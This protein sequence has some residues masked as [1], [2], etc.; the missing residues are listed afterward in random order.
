MDVASLIVRVS[1]TGVQTTQAQL[2]RLS[3]TA[4]NAQKSAGGLNL[5]MIGLTATLG[6]LTKEAIK[7]GDEWTNINSKLNLVT[8]TTQDFNKAQ[9]ELFNISQNTRTSL[10]AS[11]EL[12]RKLAVS[13]ESLNIS[14]NRLL[15][16]TETIN[17]AGIV[18]GGSKESINA[19]LIQ[20]G[21][22]LASGALRGEELNSV[23]EQ[24]P[25]LAKLIADG[26]GV[27]VGALKSLAEAG[28]ITSETIIKA[29][30]AGEKGIAKEFDVVQATISSAMDVIEGS[31][32][33][34]VG[35]LDSATGATRSLS[36]AMIELSKDI[37]QNN[38]DI[39][40]TGQFIYATISRTIDV[41]NVLYESVENTGQIVVGNINLLAYGSLEV[42]LTMLTKVTE[43]LNVLGLASDKGL[44]E[45]YSDLAY[46][47]G[48]VTNANN[49]IADSYDDLNKA[50]IKLSP[51]IEDRIKGY[52]AENKA[53]TEKLELQKKELA[54][55]Q[56]KGKSKLEVEAELK[57]EKEKQE[58]EKKSKQQA[59]KLAEDWSKRNIE[60]TTNMAIA[61]QDELAK[62]FIVL[63]A[64]YKEDLETFK[65]VK[66]A[67]ERLTLEY[68][69]EVERQLKDLTEK[70]NKEEEAKAKKSAEWQVKMLEANEK[71]N[72]EIIKMQDEMYGTDTT[73]EAWYNNQLEYLGK[74]SQEAGATA[75]ELQTLLDKIETLKSMK[76]Q[77]QTIS[78]KV[79]QS[80][81]SSFESN[82]ADSIEDAF[83]GTLNFK[84]FFRNIGND[85]MKTLSSSLASVGTNMLRGNYSALAA[86]G[87]ASA[88][89][90]GTSISA[91][92]ISGIMNNGGTFDS[93][94]NTITTSGGT[95]IA[96]D[97]SG[98]GTVSS[99]GSDIMSLVNTVGTLKTA[100]TLATAG[101]STTV[102]N[103]FLGVSDALMSAGMYESAAGVANFGYGF[104]NP[105]SY[106]AAN[107]T[108]AAMAGG[109]A[110]G[111]LMGGA[112]GYGAGYLGDKLMGA[113]T[114]ASTTGAIG[115]AAAGGLYS[116]GMISGPVGWAVLGASLLLGG[117]FGKKKVTDVGYQFFDNMTALDEITTD[118]VKQYSDWKKKSWFSSKSGT[119]YSNLSSKEMKQ[120]ESVF[121][122]YDYLLGQLGD[123]DKIWLDAG[124]YTGASFG[125]ALSRNFISA[126]T[127][128]NQNND[129]TFYQAW[130]DYAESIDATVMEA[131]TTMI[132]GFI[133]AK[134]TFEVWALGDSIEAL[135]KK[136]E[137]ATADLNQIKDTLGATD[138][139]VES[140]LSDFD[141]AVKESFTP[142]TISQWESLGTALMTAT[143]ASSAYATALANFIK[144]SN[145][146]ISNFDIWSANSSGNTIDGLKIKAD[147]LQTSFS[148]L[149]KSMGLSGIT[150]DN[151]VSTY[152][153]LA[154]E[155]GVINQEMTTDLQSLGT[156]L[157]TATDAQNAY[158]T[159]LEQQAT[160]TANANAQIALSLSQTLSV[161]G[162]IFDEIDSILSP[163]DNGFSNLTSTATILAQNL[164]TAQD[165]LI[166]LQNA[167]DDEINS[168]EDVYK[169]RVD[170]LNV[171]KETLLNILE[172]LKEINDI[173]TTLR[174]NTFSNN[175]N[176]TKSNY[177]STVSSIRD[178][179]SNNQDISPFTS[180]LSTY[181]DMYSED[182]K[183]TAKTREEYLFGVTSL[184]NE[185]ESLSNTTAT[186]ASL[187]D[188]E[189]EITVLNRDLTLTL[190]T[191]NSTFRTSLT[192]LKTNL[193]T[194]MSV[195]IDSNA[196]YL[197]EGSLLI[198]VLRS[199]NENL[200]LNYSK[201]GTPNS[202]WTPSTISSQQSIINAAGGIDAYMSALNS[203]TS[204]ADLR[205]ASQAK[206]IS[207]AGGIDA[208]MAL[209]NSGISDTDLM[210]RYGFANGGYTGNIG[211]NDIAGVVHGQ[212]YVVNA[213]TTK[214]LGLNG[215]GGAFADMVAELASLRKLMV[216]LVSD[217]TKQL[218]TQRAILGERVAI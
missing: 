191:I 146:F 44:K 105:W 63:E 73:V 132:G 119:N 66:G 203:G 113:N 92:D 88:S 217:N 89:L 186:D 147:Y 210:H 102:M 11:V 120:I 62:P 165:Y 100:Y 81:Y 46:V 195:L 57:L 83:N 33:K 79:E 194:D 4:S 181:A 6:L 51:T 123:T 9:T 71:Y 56:T 29:A 137:F 12:Y 188:V 176:Y 7:M 216:K 87:S 95:K 24:T 43:G 54:Q 14:Q 32:T 148:E 82:L 133:Q 153:K 1:T 104:A 139:T 168:I 207:N 131:F 185:I 124:K 16:V 212:E 50:V 114:Y 109:V 108:G 197:G 48:L 41:F 40:A 85:L 151:F 116:A 209:L 150:V 130:V 117:L 17:K 70:F 68:N 156:A 28:K 134:R 65:G 76:L 129:A 160:A 2:D 90:V 167:R 13:T 38:T 58:A 103:G 39:V 143:D 198:D 199:I 190:D 218:S 163:A 30:E 128:V 93:A 157:M 183:N 99:T 182:I 98:A 91:G 204:D 42:I 36:M 94:S 175:I 215:S 10:S 205:T 125:D 3:A 179:L 69:A 61:Q 135:A 72:D 145:D 173:A 18:G 196:Q 166:N 213:Q 37:N 25:R 161:Y 23:L 49:L 164:N 162:S 177:L 214:D 206:I 138:T 127:D 101:L 53:I 172:S 193:S 149:E 202:Y 115:G 35:T 189:S 59:I 170:G 77:K 112:V 126:F 80:F 96:L 122:T 31:I 174:D 78:F 192:S 74:L 169:V 155:N 64:K 136:S 52:N 15:K 211:V 178:A 140:F 158:K 97:S 152:D 121:D 208:Y 154:Y 47:Q 55:N 67:K 187:L 142:E 27:Q 200:V 144:A 180:D 106:A 86:L 34:T 141:K 19:A 201:Q 75:E 8:K 26:M 111:A 45:A 21:Q 60:I 20:L 159:A 184:A 22:G 110:S 5:G 171:E 118:T 107:P 84:K